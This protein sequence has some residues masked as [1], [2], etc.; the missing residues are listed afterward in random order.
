[1]AWLRGFLL[2]NPRSGKARPTAEELREEAVGRGLDVHMLGPGEDVA[3]LA[4]ETS[5][6]A[7]GIAGGDG[8]LAAVAAA[9]VERDVPFVCVPFGT[10]NHF[11]QDLGIDR[12]DPIAALEAFGGT[13]RRIDLGRVNDRLFL[14]NVSI[15][16]YARLV[17]HR[18]RRRRRREVLA[19][20]R[21]ILIALNHRSPRG[22]TVDGEPVTFRVLLVSNNRYELDLLSLGERER[23]DEGCLYLYVATGV[24]RSRWAERAGKAF[25]VSATAGFVRAAVDGEP[26]R[27]ETPL[28]FSVAE[29]ALRVLVPP[30]V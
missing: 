10:R 16:M 3:R 11:A 25:R 17:H 27:L 9:A 23:L 2:I 24:V 28:E 13:E 8:S 20:A 18:E 26:A 22:M 5:A 6:D 4:R 15:G 12:R 7:I 1:L 19:R 30:G 14:N 29:R 21:A